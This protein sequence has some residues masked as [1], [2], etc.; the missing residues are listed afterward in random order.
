MPQG[1]PS[2]LRET[3]VPQ[4]KLTLRGNY[5]AVYRNVNLYQ[6]LFLEAGF[7]TVEF[8][9]NYAYTNMEAAVELVEIRRNNLRFLPAQSRFLGAL[10]WYSLRTIAPAQFLAVASCPVH[11][12]RS[13]GPV[14]KITFSD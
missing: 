7:P 4:G 11:G 13:I 14:Y 3:T 12:S 5:Q 9:R 1:H 6:D 8:R 2:F 10:T